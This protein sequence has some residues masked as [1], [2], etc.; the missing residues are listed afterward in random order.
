MDKVFLFMF[1]CFRPSI[2]DFNACRPI[3][4]VDGIFLRGPYKGV[5]LVASGWDAN[6]HVY[7]LAFVIVDEE[8]TASWSWFLRLLKRYVVPNRLIC[9]ISNR[10]K[11]ILSAFNRHP[12]LQSPNAV[13]MYCLRHVR[14]N[15]KVSFKKKELTELIYKARTTTK[16]QKF[17]SI[18][19]EI[20]KRDVDAYN[21]LKAI[22]QEKWTL[23]HDGGIQVRMHDH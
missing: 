1:W 5:L 2:N 17:N 10:H 8:S 16:M 15:F 3:I 20:K 14:A 21:Y 7:L 22:D 19:E 9:I 11:G 18:L 13:H 4:S 6:N 12:E 23:A